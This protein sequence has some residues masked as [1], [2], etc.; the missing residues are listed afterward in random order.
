M[1]QIISNDNSVINVIASISI[2]NPLISNWRRIT[3]IL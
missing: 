2:K 1:D 3:H